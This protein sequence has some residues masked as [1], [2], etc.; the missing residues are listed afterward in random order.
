MMTDPIADM[1]T[2]IRNGLLNKHG[3]VEVPMSKTKR[4]IADILKAEGYIEDYE[5]K[6]DAVQGTLVVTLR[7]Q[8]EE[9]ESPIHGLQRVSTPGRRIYSKSDEIPQVLGGLGIAIVSTSKGLLTD[10]QA[11]E[12]VKLR[13]FAGM[14]LQYAANAMGVSPRTADRLWGYARAWLFKALRTEG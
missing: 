2:R 10:K 9:M 3:S 5:V 13:Y 8:G 14:T 4:R 6:E 12:L 11:A 1:L 7:Y